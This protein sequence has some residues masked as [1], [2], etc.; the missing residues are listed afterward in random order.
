[1][2]PIDE[3][4]D[5][6][7]RLLTDNPVNPVS[8]LQKQ[9]ILASLERL[10]RIDEVQVPDEPEVF[11]IPIE[12]GTHPMVDLQ[13]YRTLRDLLKKVTVERELQIDRLEL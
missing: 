9:S 3:Q 11:W 5:Y 13:D 7:R 10:K 12:D 2:I 8:T 6:Q 4:I 1:M